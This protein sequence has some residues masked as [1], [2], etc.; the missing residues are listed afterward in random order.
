MYERFSDRGRKVMQLANKEA[1]RFNHE[2]VGAEHILL[3]LVRERRGVAANVLKNLG[4]DPRKIR[5]EVEEIVAERTWHR[6]AGRT[7]VDSPC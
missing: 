7:A 6:H 2:H 1:Q 3:G 5:L 4:V